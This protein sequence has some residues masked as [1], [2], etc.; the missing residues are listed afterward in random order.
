MQS[1]AVPKPKIVAILARMDWSSVA[2]TDDEMIKL[3]A[4]VQFNGSEVTYDASRADVNRVVSSSRVPEGVDC[5]LYNS[6]GT[7][8]EGG[9]FFQTIE[10]KIFMT[11]IFSILTIIGFFGNVMVITVVRKVKGMITPTNCY[12]TSLAISDSLFFLATTPVEIAYLY[13]DEYVFGP[14]GCAVMSYLPYLAINLSSLSITAF[15]IE[16]Y[17]GI[18]KPYLA[19]QVCTVER[20][21]LILKGIWIFALLYNSPWMFLAKLTT[22]PE[23]NLTM[24][25]F[26]LSRDNIAYRILY[27]FD[28]LTFY[29]FPMVLN[30]FIYIK[31]YFVLISCGDRLKSTAV[32]LI[33]AG[34]N[35]SKDEAPP[36]Q[37]SEFLISGGRSRASTRGG[38][39]SVV[40]MLALVVV[41]FATCWFPYRAMVFYNSYAPE[42]HLYRPEWYLFF[43]KTLVF[44]NCSVNPILYNLMSQ[45]F[46][47]AFKSLLFGKRNRSFSPTMTTVTRTRTMTTVDR[48]GR[49]VPTMQNEQKALVGASTPSIIDRYSATVLP[50]HLQ[51]THKHY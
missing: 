17:F 1:A 2:M 44:V 18:C 40:K 51:Y 4:G 47:S 24:C 21:N 45:R 20:A 38:K 5:R 22:D 35:S 50:S 25:E 3:C 29:A 26:S 28:I 30:I 10:F 39:N 46:R 31:I 8:S 34:K 14:V 48:E 19:R 33:S 9:E 32:T 23:T 11:F 49:T 15:T 36:A 16:R 42:G 27:T 12:L 37:T 43:A 6:N 13:T 7:D 41:V